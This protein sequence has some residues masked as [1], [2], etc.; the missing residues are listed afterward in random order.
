MTAD[1]PSRTRSAIS[2]DILKLPGVDGRSASGRRFRDL[3]IAFCGEVGGVDSLTEPQRALVAQAAT[4]TITV[5]RLQARLIAG[6]AIDP[7]MI[8]RTANVQIRALQ[9]LGLK[10]AERNAEGGGGA[11][12]AYLAELAARDA[13]AEDNEPELADAADAADVAAL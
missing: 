1:R 9:A 12:H 4:L 3:V 6:E 13:D 2:N 8:V 11:L 7:E 5:E 10:K